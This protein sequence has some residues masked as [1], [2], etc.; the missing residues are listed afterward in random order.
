MMDR[1]TLSYLKAGAVNVEYPKMSPA[2]NWTAIF[3]LREDLR[4]PGYDEVFLS[5]IENPYIKPIDK[6]AE[7]SKK[8][9]KGKKLGRGQKA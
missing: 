5:C 3:S 9:K 7:E 4:P 2:P 6:R 1:S 8:K